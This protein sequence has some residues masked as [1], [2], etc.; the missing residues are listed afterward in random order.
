[1]ASGESLIVTIGAV[2]KNDIAT[3]SGPG[4]AGFSVNPQIRS[5]KEP[6]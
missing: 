5:R 6:F 1:M 2:T 3:A 4:I